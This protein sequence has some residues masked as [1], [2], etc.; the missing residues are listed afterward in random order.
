M[1]K[2]LCQF[3]ETDKGAC[4]CIV[5]GLELP[6]AKQ[7]CGHVYHYCKV[8]ET[9]EARV[10]RTANA[11]SPEAIAERTARM[12]KRPGWQLQRLIVK[13]LGQ[14]A[15]A[16]CGCESMIAKM[17]QWGVVGCR[18]NI[19]PITDRL[20]DVATKKEWVLEPEEGVS[21][22]D[23][24]KPVPQTRRTRFLRL[25]ART[26]SVTDI[27]AGFVRGQCRAMATLAIHRAEREIVVRSQTS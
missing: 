22:D 11:R 4:R 16:G 13:R 27:G 17:N 23:I 25:L 6:I 19:E 2:L 15:I 8:I 9:P 14:K 10:K 26:M 7:G 3:D 18:K 5:C 24:G 12:R 20:V 21:P 1:T